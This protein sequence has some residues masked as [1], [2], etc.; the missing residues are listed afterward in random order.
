MDEAWEEGDRVRFDDNPP[1]TVLQRIPSGRKFSDDYKV[2]WDTGH[3]TTVWGSD[4][5]PA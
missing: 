2:R 5:V 3:I 4:L 1:G